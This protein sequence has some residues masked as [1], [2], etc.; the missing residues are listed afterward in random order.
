M[1]RNVR[2]LFWLC[3]TMMLLLLCA[4][5]GVPSQE[6]AQ[7]EDSSDTATGSNTQKAEAPGPDFDR[8]KL[9]EMAI[10]LTAYKEMTLEELLPESFG[11]SNLGQ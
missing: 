3:L 4:S 11:P 9:I 1:K 2:I 7:T 6:T 8:A 10:S 5:C